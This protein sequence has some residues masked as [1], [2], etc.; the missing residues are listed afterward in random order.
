MSE[1]GKNM[2][3]MSID[4]GPLKRKKTLE[5]YDYKKFKFMKHVE[6][7]YTFGKVLG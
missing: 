4:Q 2:T 1:I 6:Q 5:M 3:A 7:R